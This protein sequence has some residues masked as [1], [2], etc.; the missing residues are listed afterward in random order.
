MGHN[1]YDALSLEGKRFIYEELPR[2][3]VDEDCRQ[4][5]V[6]FKTLVAYVMAIA[7]SLCVIGL[8]I[9]LVGPVLGILIFSA[10][11]CGFFYVDRRLTRRAREEA[12][13]ARACRFMKY[14]DFDLTPKGR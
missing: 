7:S 6:A 2:A 5:S 12:E 4:A 13:S 3:S 10:A 11:M 9:N 8:L 14:E 1:G